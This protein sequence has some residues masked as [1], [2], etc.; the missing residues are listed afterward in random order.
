MELSQRFLTASEAID[1]IHGERWKG[2]KNG[3]TNTRAL[4]EALNHPEERIGRVIHVAGTNGKGSTC[5]MIE[6]ALRECGYTT[7]LF[8]SPYLCRFHERIRLCGVPIS[9][10]DLIETAS[11]VREAA[12]SLAEKGIYCTTFE[13]LTAMACV[14][15]AEKKT[16]YAVMEV[17]MGGRLDSTNVLT[18]FVSVIAAIGMDHMARLGNTLEAIAGEKAGIIKPRVP[19]VVLTQRENV[20]GVFRQT[21]REQ[22]APLFETPVPAIIQKDAHGAYFA[23]DLPSAGLVRARISLPG[24]HQIQN[25]SLALMVLDRLNLPM[26]RAIEGLSKTQWPGRLEWIGNVLIDGAHN[27]QG[28]LALAN[29]AREYL[30]EKR[31]VLLTG[32]M[33]DKQ[34]AECARI[35]SQ[36]AAEIVTTQVAWP[37]ALPAQTLAEVY[38]KRAKA[39]ESLPDALRVSQRLAGED[40]IVI[41]AGSIYTAGDVRNL[42]LP[43]DRGAI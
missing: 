25:T 22:R 42:L 8:T 27:P 11:F 17:G 19:A 3:L 29:Y 41:C 16:Q 7:G 20:M 36:F 6:R 1:W 13:I 15:F 34:Y 4:L 31:V 26:D 10:D 43:D 21:A 9:D 33:Q 14:Y 35:F 38:G 39:V 5:A 12:Q 40:G 32:M 30:S 24:A 37:R 18:P 23:L 2:E 28:A